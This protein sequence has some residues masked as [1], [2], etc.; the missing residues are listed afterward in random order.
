[1][2]DEASTLQRRYGSA[3]QLVVKVLLVGMCILGVLWILDVPSRLGMLIYFEQWMGLFLALV[4]GVA[5]ITTPASKKLASKKLPWYDVALS[6]AGVVVG[7][8][9]AINW[10]DIVNTA[11]ILM[12]ERIVLGIIAT[13]LV[14]EATRRFFGWPLVILTLIF[15]AYALLGKYF[16]GPL[17]TKSIPWPRLSTALYL[18]ANGLFGIGLQTAATLILAFLIFGQI[19]ADTKG[20]KFL[21]DL[22]LSIFGRMKGGVAKAPVAA[23]AAFGTISGL[24]VA[25]I[26]VIGQT[27]I[28]IMKKHGVEPHVAAGILAAAATGA[29]LMPPVMGVVAFIMA[30]FLNTSYANVVIAAT[31]PAVLYFLA[32]YVQVDRYAVSKG[33]G[34]LPPEEIPA[35]KKVVKEGWIFI[36]PIIVFIYTLFVM[37]LEADTSVLYATAAVLLIT[38]ARKANRLS[39]R[40]FLT[41]LEKAGRDILALGVV[42]AVVGLIIGSFLFTGLGFSLTQVIIGL[43]GGN[44]FLILL[45]AA[46]VNIILGT[47]MPQVIVYI[48]VVLIVAP[49][50]TQAGIPPM[51]THL[52]VFYYGLLSFLTPPVCISIYA[53]S[54]IAGAGI[55][56]SAASG[57]RLS[58]VA[59]IVPFFFVYDTA[60]I[61]IG[62]P[63][64]I[65]TSAVAAFAGV[66]LLA[67]GIQ[68][69]WLRHLGWIQRIL[70]VG[71][72]GLLMTPSVT[73]R[74]IGLG[75]GALMF[76]WEFLLVRRRTAAQTS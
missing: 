55:W 38:L 18:D 68:G 53:S 21:V 66:I 72:G 27:T 17:Q 76:V 67:L 1:M 12:T 40:G 7:L 47:G 75:L 57:I 51:A 29:I 45:I 46:I 24:A 61:A 35:I 70:L 54:A 34:S 44:I 73:T 16:P 33:I 9:A 74:L 6:I 8:Y 56:R 42:C 11:G 49:T 26:Y 39:I 13:L 63:L 30:V 19:L 4:L 65:I 5:F 52:F 50:L 43:A 28:P 20:G 2:V 41:S 69:Y 71:G 22:S 48:I 25:T 58:I 60:L 14:L 59:Y 10:P 3:L 31:I 62:T 32:I 36:I 37:S 23:C 64:Q 15:I